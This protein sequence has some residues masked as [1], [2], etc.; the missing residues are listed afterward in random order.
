MTEIGQKKE[1]NPHLLS[2]SDLCSCQRAAGLGWSLALGRAVRSP[3][4]FPT[5]CWSPAA[6][7]GTCTDERGRIDSLTCRC[8]Y[9][10]NGKDPWILDLFT[11]KEV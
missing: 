10:A 4:R 8:A 6:A 1:S 2:L 7:Q 5:P 11:L 3:G 9:Q